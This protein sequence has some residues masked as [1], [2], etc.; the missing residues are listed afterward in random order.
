MKILVSESAFTDLEEIIEY[1]NEQDIPNVGIDTVTT[2][3]E[4]FQILLTHPE[5]GRTVPEFNDKYIR[6]I[7]HP[8]YRIVYLREIKTV[9]IIRVWRSERIL[10]LPDNET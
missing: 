5:I 6:E 1:Y 4:H 10:K 8:P 2:T 3:I 9:Q 7:I